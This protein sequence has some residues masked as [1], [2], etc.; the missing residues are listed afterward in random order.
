M[1]LGVWTIFVW[2]CLN[3][4]VCV[5]SKA[6]L[7]AHGSVLCAL[8][9]CTP[10]MYGCILYACD[11][12]SWLVFLDGDKSW[13]SVAGYP[14][15]VIH[16]AAFMTFHSGTQLGPLA[17]CPHSLLWHDNTIPIAALSVLHSAASVTP[18]TGCIQKPDLAKIEMWNANINKICSMPKVPWRHTWIR[19]YSP[20]CIIARN[21]MQK[22]QS[23]LLTVSH[24]AQGRNGCN[25]HSSQKQSWF[26]SF[27]V[28]FHH[29]TWNF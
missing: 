25:N 6:F 16:G 8:A 7:S 1:T 23:T 28:G 13:G 4:Y 21:Y 3:V 29:K 18:N 9:W 2:L 19:K 24:N 20:V 15:E 17:Q 14:T 22:Y 26:L 10:G 5:K 27:C 12:L 11:L